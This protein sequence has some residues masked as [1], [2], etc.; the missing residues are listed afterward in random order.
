VVEKETS[1]RRTTQELTCL[2]SE[3][4]KELKPR[5]L[6]GLVAALGTERAEA[7][8][9]RYA[10]L[11]LPTRRL[12]LR[13][14]W[15]RL[16]GE[17]EP[18]ADAKIVKE[19]RQRLG[20]ATVERLALEVE[21]GI[22]VP[23]LLLLPARKA[24]T[25]LPV[26][27]AFAQRGKQA[28]LKDRSAALAELL[29]AGTAICLPDLRGTGETQP[30]D[31]ARS[32]GSAS[33]SLSATELMLGQTLLGAR[34]RDLRSVL[35]YLRS[36]MDLHPKR[37]ALWGDSF[38]PANP[39]ERNLAVPLDADRLPDQAEP[40][41]GLLALLGALFD[42]DIRAVY[43][44]GGL[45]SFRSLLDSPFCY[46]PHDAVI[47]GALTAGDLCDVAA[48]LAPLPMRLEGLV[49]GLDREVF[50]DA[51]NRIFEPAR[52]EYGSMKAED[53][54]LLGGGRTGTESAARWI[55]QYIAAN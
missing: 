46:V 45:A 42:D 34:L 8:R 40:L 13:Q 25:R 29:D 5:P 12:Q 11:T 3:S 6:H 51:L 39:R 22:L 41:G 2:T 50:V 32:R 20:N 16:L 28:F 24:D 35:R 15:A 47:P 7:A 44:R 33:T 36:R 10:E 26:V 55:L 4:E 38:A 52:K 21:P 31:G 49:D 48:A 14:D 18:K 30:A 27:V 53:R 17:V 54:L 9:K 1:K 43:A 19:D 23:L 37:V